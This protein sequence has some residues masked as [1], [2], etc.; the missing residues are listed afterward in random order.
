MRKL[1]LKEGKPVIEEE[2]IVVRL[3][4]IWKKGRRKHFR[5]TKA[6]D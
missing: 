2:W 1:I 5:R 6:L 4:G 3:D